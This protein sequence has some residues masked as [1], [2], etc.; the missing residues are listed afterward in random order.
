[1][2]E[3]ERYEDFEQ[4]LKDLFEIIDVIIA[5]NDEKTLFTDIFVD[6]LFELYE[7]KIPEPLKHKIVRREKDTLYFK[8]PFSCCL[9]LGHHPVN[10]APILGFVL[11]GCHWPK[12]VPG[13]KKELSRRTKKWKEENEDLETSEIY[14][15]RKSQKTLVDFTD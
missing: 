9:T 15:V 2:K 13:L 10:M 1:M 14:N 3:K 12:F 7:G 5:L 4:N 8:V 6:Y 11:F